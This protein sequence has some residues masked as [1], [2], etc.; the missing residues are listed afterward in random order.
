MYSRYLTIAFSVFCLVLLA[1]SSC[2]K[3]GGDAGGNEEEDGNEP[4][5][6]MDFR[7]STV[8]DSSVILA[9]TA[10]GDDAD[11]GTATTYDI[12][13]A[14]S[15]ITDDNWGSATQVTGEPSPKAAGSAETFEVRG[16]EED[17]TY[18]FALET[19][20]EAGNCPNVS[21]CGPATCFVNVPI[22]F[23]DP[24]LDQAIR[25]QIGKATGQLYRADVV[26]L[27]YVDAN[28]R[29][30]VSLSGL[31][32]CP[33]LTA[34]FLSHNNI[35]DLTPFA[36][37]HKLYSVQMVSNEITDIGPLASNVNIAILYLRN[38]HVS[39]LS[40]L[41]LNYRIHL[42]DLRNNN[43]SD[44]NTLVGNLSFAATDTLYVT[45]NPLSQAAIE[46]QIPALTARGV[47]VIN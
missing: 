37:L 39:D 47:T 30:I 14:K 2:S 27:G 21:T 15:A 45:D 31:E 5:F 11:Q 34:V 22:S 25:T 46:T 13:Y 8:S 43:V 3:K 16:L 26:T 35:S 28:E 18:Y 24:A 4:Y 41:A 40:A 7:I 36:S 44:L 19:R 6:I 33:E 20:D 10:T 23:P 32:Y 42:L 29:G 9:W 12:R 17:S 38:N 1:V